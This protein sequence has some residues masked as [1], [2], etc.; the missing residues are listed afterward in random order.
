MRLGT[1]DETRL[2]ALLQAGRGLVAQ[3]E[4]DAVLEELL[5]VACELTGANYAAIG[6]LDEDRRRLERFVTRGIDRAAREAIGDLPRGHGV[7]GELIRDPAPLRLDDVSAHPRS[8]GFPAHHP[9]MRTFLGVPVVIR[10]EPWGNLYLTEKAG[11]PF[12][13]ADEAATVVL[14]DWAAL[15]VDNA[16]LYEDAGRRRAEAERALRRLEATAAI[17]RAVGSE[18]DLDRVLELVVKRGRA[19]LDARSVV[20]LLVDGEEFHLAAGAGQVAPA[21]LGGRFPIPDSAP[22]DVLFSGRPERID[23]VASRLR[24]SDQNLGVTGAT[25][26]LLVPLV[27]RNTPLGLLAAFDRL[28]GPGGFGD[29]EERLVLGFAASAATAVATARSV[30]EERLRH[31]LLAAEQERRRWARELHDQTLQALGGLQVLLGSA[32]RRGSPEALEQAVRES[33]EHIGTE[34]ESLRTLITELRPAALDEIG[35]APAIES[36]GQRLAAV[37]GLEVG[38]E[39]AVGGRLDA[40]LE[41]TVYRLVQEALT[42]I[43]KHANAESVRVGVALDYDVVRIEVTD[44]G[45]GFDPDARVEGFGLIGMRE[46]VALAHGRLDIE[47]APGRTVVRADLPLRAPSALRAS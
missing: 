8:Y 16:R 28:D 11:G 15:A 47:S 33:L 37:E 5:R 12:D 3:L 19:L 45:R 4:V 1:L 17:A 30:A 22:G 36:L 35:L 26:A 14:A 38:V 40:E 31:S 13:E 24:I 10:G 41:T 7:I 23:D 46:R 9:P 25:T 6:V 18:T 43:A 2:A 42:N 20:L 39:V 34:I 27:Y 32:L 29:E 21:A 44:D